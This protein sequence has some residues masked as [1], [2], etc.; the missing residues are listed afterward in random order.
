M[1]FYGRR[2]LPHLLHFAMRQA[3]LRPFRQRVVGAAVGKV[4]EIGL[5]SGL[6]LP[7]YGLN[8][9]SV[10]GVEP[11]AELLAM[12]ERQ[13]GRARIPV[14]LLEASAEALP[15]PSSSIDTAVT[16]WTLCTI[17]DAVQAL[18]EVRRVLKPGGVLLFVEHGRAPEPS[19][20]R[21][22]DRLDRP[23]S[24][25]AGGCHLNRPI[26]HLITDAGFRV[27]TLRHERVAGPPTHNF[28]Y[29]GQARPR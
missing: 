5:G 25:I 21:W 4:L 6:N 19:V 7:L 9:R 28:L 26:D 23:W 18:R 1:S 2:I 24:R 15:L 13:V 3:Q 16:T 22:Q 14:E 29:Q 12:A 11:S 27:E 17:P 10:I 8:V 20:A